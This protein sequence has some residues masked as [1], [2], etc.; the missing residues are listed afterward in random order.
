MLL[1]GGGE[2]AE[3]GYGCGDEF[4]GVVYFFFGGEFGEGEADAGS[5]SGGGEA[6]GGEDVGGFGCAGLTGGA[7]ADGEALEVEGDDE[8]FGFEV[9]EVKVAGV[10]DAGG[11][12][13]VDAAVVDL[14]EDALFEA[15]A[16]GGEL[17]GGGGGVE[18]GGSGRASA[19]CPHLRIEIWGTR[20]CDSTGVCGCSARSCDGVVG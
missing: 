9:I 13:S 20:I 8:G 14:G 1:P 7:S 18:M 2:L 19:R 5:G 3:V 16:Q 15:V 17:G 6:H 11:S 12:G 4:E 10:G